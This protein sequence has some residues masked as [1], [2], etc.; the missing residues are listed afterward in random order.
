MC[1]LD[2]KRGDKVI[3]SVN[4][5]PEF[6]EVVRHFDAEPI[7]VDIEDDSFEIDLEKL[8]AVLDEFNSKKLKAIILSHVSG[9][10]LD[11]QAIKDVVSE[12]E[13]LIVEDATNTLGLDREELDSISDIR[14]FSFDNRYSKMGLFA[15][16]NEEFYERAKLLSN[17]GIV[18]DEDNYLGYIY[19]VTDAG[20]DYTS[21]K[22]DLL[23]SIDVLERVSSKLKRRREIAKRYIDQLQGTP[24]ISF[25]PSYQVSHSYSHFMIKVDKNRDGF[26]K[27][28][29]ERGIETSLHYIPLHL[30][31][32]YKNKY[33][34]KINS[35]PNALRNYQQVLSIPIHSYLSDSDVDYIID[36]IK[37]IAETRV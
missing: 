18:R 32:Y 29:Q 26:A 10:V 37:S 35:Y 34:L 15:T 33:E 22:I 5:S 16:D 11:I 3:C 6:P 20:C 7:F 8:Q 24:H 21:S 4:A 25:D 28:L 36:S 27:L 17:H 1:A 13:L 2:L 19:D 9:K 30:L 23:F 14:L 31:S 12:R